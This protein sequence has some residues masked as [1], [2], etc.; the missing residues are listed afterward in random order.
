MSQKTKFILIS[1]NT[2]I[3]VATIGLHGHNMLQSLDMLSIYNDGVFK[4]EH[5]LGNSN[6]LDA[7]SYMVSSSSFWLIRG[8]QNSQS[9]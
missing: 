5:I 4:E 2:M 3:F 1:V 6:V 8:V 9:H 7:V